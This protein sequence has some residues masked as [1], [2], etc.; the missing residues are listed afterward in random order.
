MNFCHFDTLS[1]NN[2]IKRYSS[3]KADNFLTFFDFDNYKPIIIISRWTQCPFE[4]FYR[5]IKSKHSIIVLYSIIIFHIYII[6]NIVLVQQ[7]INIFEL[8]QIIDIKFSPLK[9][10]N[11][12]SCLLADFRI[13]FIYWP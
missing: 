11:Q 5:I 4:K 10:R 12:F 1:F 13:L 7:C 6:T 2:Y 9:F 3:Y 8:F